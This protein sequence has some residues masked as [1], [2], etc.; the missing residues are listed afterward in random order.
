LLKP[1]DRVVDPFGG[2]ALGALDAMRC[3]LDWTGCELEPKFVALG[4]GN[5]DLWRGRYAPHFAGWGT[6]RL[7]QCDSRQLASVVAEAEVCV[8]SPPYSDGA[9][10]T[11]GDARMTTGQGGAIRF[12]DYGNTPGQLG[13]MPAGDFDAAVSSPPYA[14]AR[15]DGNGDEGASGL[16]MPDGSF[17]RG[18]DGWELRKGQGSRYGESDANLGNLPAGDFDATISSPPYENSVH[19]GNGIDPAKLTGNTAGARSQAFSEGY[20]DTAGQL[21]ATSGDT[22]WSASRAI[23]EQVHLLLKPGG[24]AVWVVK[25]YVRN[26]Q[27]VPFCDHWRQLCEAVG[28]ATLHEHHAWLVEEHGAQADIF[29]EIHAKRIERKSFWRRL[30]ERN[31]QPRIDWETVLCMRKL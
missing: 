22:F 14:A 17:V 26:R 9:Q 31:G 3:G 7:L 10:H 25:D 24:V 13:A 21:G 20:G 12:V 30:N 28:F 8:S 23:V 18:A 16:R 27:I 19:S 1:G 2:V 11:G 29:G 4:Q 6:A 5:I 15:I